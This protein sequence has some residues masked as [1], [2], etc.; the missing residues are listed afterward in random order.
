MTTPSE[1][2]IK[3]RRDDEGDVNASL[4]KQLGGSLRFLCNSRPDIS[5]GV[6]LINKFMSAPKKSHLAAAKRILRYL[7][8]TTDSAILFPRQKMVGKELEL[9][10]FT[11]SDYSGDSDDRKSTYGYL[12]QL[13]G[14][15]ISRTSKKQPVI[16]LSSCEA[17][18]IAGSFAACQAVWLEELL[19]EI[20]RASCRERV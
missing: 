17:E 6:G 8:G 10:G 14:A 12:F 4:F 20:G 15:P 11:D 16:A 7:Q 13:H 5:Y 2:N 19:K 9:I 18:Y 1:V 3:L